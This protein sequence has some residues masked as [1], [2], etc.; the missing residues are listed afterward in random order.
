M[1]RTKLSII[2]NGAAAFAIIILFYY[3]F[4]ARDSPSFWKKFSPSYR[5]S[6]SARVCPDTSDPDYFQKLAK[7]V[8]VSASMQI[9]IP[10]HFL[11]ENCIV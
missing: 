8:N 6:S 2:R 1:Y 7:S 5:V 4:N 10:N 9:P 3:V 11:I